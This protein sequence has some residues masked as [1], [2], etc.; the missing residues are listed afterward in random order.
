[1]KARTSAA[2]KDTVSVQWLYFPKCD[3]PPELALKIIEA[4]STTPGIASAE[5]TENSNFVL[6]LLSEP[7]RAMGFRVEAGKLSAQKVKVPVLFGRNGVALKTFEADAFHVEQGFVLEVEAG[8]AVANNRFL[9]DLFQACL[10]HGVDYVAIAVRSIYRES[11]DFD[12]VAAF[13]E[14]L[15][16]SGRLTLPLKGVLLIG[17]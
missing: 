13:F 5:Q 12:R 9:K 6:Q 16:A 11:A 17:Y 3:R 4:F 10:M 14:A 15:Y 2:A 1:M 7:L 8:C